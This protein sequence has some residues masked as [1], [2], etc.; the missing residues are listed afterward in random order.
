MG[1]YKPPA[2]RQTHLSG[3][4]ALGA[5]FDEMLG[6]PKFTGDILRLVYHA[7]GVWLSIFAIQ[8]TKNP[9]FMALSVFL[10]LGMASAGVLDVIS[11]IQRGTGIHPQ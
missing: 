6:L 3:R 8:R 5:L 11:L 9:W 2:Y 10:G 4:P 1:P 7:G